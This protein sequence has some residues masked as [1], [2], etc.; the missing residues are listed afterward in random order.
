MRNVHVRIIALSLVSACLGALTSCPG[1]YYHDFQFL[2]TMAPEVPFVLPDSIGAGGFVLI[3][4][5]RK[6]Y[7][8]CPGLHVYDLWEVN[9]KGRIGPLGQNGVYVGLETTPD[10]GPVL[11]VL[12]RDEPERPQL[13]KDWPG[14]VARLAV[15]GSSHTVD[16][17]PARVRAVGARQAVTDW[18][19]GVRP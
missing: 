5:D 7:P 1:R 16:S 18:C 4:T 11:H 3:P 8:E 19:K 2:L 17:V 15:Q 9:A 10:L 12:M 14:I 13:P 6:R